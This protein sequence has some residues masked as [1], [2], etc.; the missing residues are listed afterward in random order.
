MMLLLPLLLQAS[1]GGFEQSSVVALWAVTAPLGALMFGRAA[2]RAVVLAFVAVDR[3][4][5]RFDPH[6]PAKAT[7]PRVVVTFFVLNLLGVSTTDY[8]VLRYFIGE[9]ERILDALRVE[10]D[11]SE[12][13]LLKSYQR[14]S[15][16][17]RRNARRHRRHGFDAVTVLFADIVGFTTFAAAPPARRG[18][19]RTQP[20]VHPFDELADRHGL[21]KIKT[22]GDAYMVVGRVPSPRADHAEAIAEMALDMR[23]GGR[24]LRARPVRPRGTGRH[25]QRAG[26]GRRHRATK[27]QLRRLGRHG[28]HGQPHGGPR[29]AGD[30]PGHRACPRAASRSLRVRARGAID[31]KGLGPTRTYLLVGRRQL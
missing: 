29:D 16:T 20:V 28:E 7:F 24:H 2:R 8:L 18:R 25:E 31:V 30:D 6:C 3:L 19:R 13:L 15:P 22:I 1:I 17:A 21:E 10:Q 5:R 12:R 26:G 14:R 23:A 4:F 11:R 9:R 27:I